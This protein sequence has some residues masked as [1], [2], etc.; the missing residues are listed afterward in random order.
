MKKYL[1][2]SLTLIALYS[3][4]S[5]TYDELL[6]KGEMQGPITYNGHIKAII[7]N[8]CIMCHSA[9]GAS[10]FRPLTNYTQVREAVL[11]TNLLDRIQRQNGEEGQMP[12]TGRMP[13]DKIN[14]ILQWNAEGLPEN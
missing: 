13:Q 7:D 12:Q 3:C 8:N 5:H 10:S 9:G 4:E 1:I 2:P 6:D 14:L 11:T